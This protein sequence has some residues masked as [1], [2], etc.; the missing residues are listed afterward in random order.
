MAVNK[1]CYYRHRT[2]IY[3]TDKKSNKG[4]EDCVRYNIWD[5][6]DE[7][8]KGYGAGDKEVDRFLFTKTVAD[9]G[10]DKSANGDASPE[11]RG[12]VSNL[13]GVSAP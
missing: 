7:D 8:L 2:G 4:D 10:K 9:G 1:P 12:D 11:T 6:P 13:C 3:R 5:C